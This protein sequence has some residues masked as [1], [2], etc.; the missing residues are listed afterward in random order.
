VLKIVIL[1]F[2]L[3]PSFATTYRIA[4]H[5]SCP[6]FCPEDEN[7][8]GYAIDI[9]RAYLNTKKSNLKIVQT[10]YARVPSLLT[11]GLSDIAVG[12]TL[13]SRHTSKLVAYRSQLGL[14]S[15]GALFRSREELVVLD[16]ADL[17]KKR[18]LL[19]KGSRATVL[20]TRELEKINNSKGF[21]NEV[22]GAKIHERLIEL[23]ALKRGDVALDDYNVLKYYLNLNANRN[24]ISLTPTSLT[25]HN[26]I[27]VV[28]VKGSPLKNIF[29]RDLIKYIDSIRRSGK[30]KKILDKY[31]I[32][33]WDRFTSR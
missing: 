12:S 21:L 7:K 15:T 32:S 27:S 14:R 31:N 11:K 5:P 22:T 30:L 17:E 16:F 13:D 6:Y 2:I 8:E 24:V 18:V 3:A 28:A 4:I 29:Q 23:I 9:L 26:P 25:G 20:I 33:D 10:P 1:Y 19:A